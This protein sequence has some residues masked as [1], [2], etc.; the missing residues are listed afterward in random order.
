MLKVFLEQLSSPNKN[1]KI[2][3]KKGTSSIGRKEADLIVSDSKVSSLHAE[4]HFNGSRVYIYDKNST[5]GTYV[6]SKRIK[7]T[8]LK[9]GDTISLSG[10]DS[11][12]SVTYRLH[13]VR[14]LE[15]NKVI[16][17]EKE[18]KK[19]KYYLSLYWWHFF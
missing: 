9:N 1:L 6:N 10:L 13:I 4:I 19:L 7:K 11:S 8:S 15:K 3:L 12:A 5:N 2:E 14:E 18:A 16:F 17:I